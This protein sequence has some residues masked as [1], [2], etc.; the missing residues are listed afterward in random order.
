MPIVPNAIVEEV[1][2]N[3]PATIRVF[4]AFK[5]GCVGCPIA[6]FHTV[7]DACREHAVDADLFLDRLREVAAAARP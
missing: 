6:G 3:F 2:R 5:M 7:R 4:L 1:M